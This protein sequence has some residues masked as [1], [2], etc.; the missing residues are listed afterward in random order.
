MSDQ[1]TS[2]SNS[3]ETIQDDDPQFSADSDF[4]QAVRSSKQLYICGNLWITVD[5]PKSAI[6]VI[7]RDLVYKTCY[8]GKFEAFSCWS[9]GS[10]WLLTDKGR[11]NLQTKHQFSSGTVAGPWAVGENFIAHKDLARMFDVGTPIIMECSA[12]RVIL[13]DANS[14]KMRIATICDGEIDVSDFTD[15]KK[16]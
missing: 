10:A 14:G 3:W 6:L 9:D 11:L 5:E 15:S 12:R 4:L 16:Y 7:I 1:I 2:I 13:K 8:D